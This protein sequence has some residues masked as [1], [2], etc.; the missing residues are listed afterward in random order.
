MA[1]QNQTIEEIRDLIIANFESNF[2][3]K[4]RLLPKS[5]L[6]IFASIIAGVYIVLFKS[7][8]WIFLQFFP[9]TAYFG[10]I[11][12]LNKKINPLV[13]LGE[14]YGIGLPRTGTAWEGKVKIIVLKTRNLLEQNTQ[15]KSEITGKIYLTKTTVFLTDTEVVLD[16]YCAETGTEGNIEID[17]VVQFSQPL[18]FV[19]KDSVVVEVSK[20]ATD[21]ETEESY[22]S[23][24]DNIFKIS[25]NGGS[26]ADYRLWSL[27]VDGVLQAYPYT[28]P[29]SASGVLVYIAGEPNTF[30]DRIPTKDLLISVGMS[31]TYNPNTGESRKP[32]TAI[33]DPLFNESF[34]NIRSI[35]IIEFDIYINNVTGVN[36]FDFSQA[37]KSSLQNYL[38][39]REPYIR[40]LSFDDNKVD[41]ISKNNVI[42]ICDSIADDLK[43]TF[44]NVVVLQDGGVVTFYTLEFG[45]LAK[46]NRLFVNGEEF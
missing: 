40:G 41:V 12:I 38:L 16:V 25:P 11:T 21:A 23:R 35:S 8:G 14:M 37:I 33:I 46:L 30:A 3:T 45:Q 39:E 20:L 17:D 10:D 29:N 31:I 34:E 9:K 36:P 22:R 26:L 15:L 1:I 6:R 2:N 5:F 43:A 28:D 13:A 18:G 44:E 42:G 24:V 7:M 4:F 27:E 32:L 19:D